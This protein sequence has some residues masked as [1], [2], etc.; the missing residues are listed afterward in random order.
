[1]F[2][3]YSRAVSIGILG[4][5]QKKGQ[6]QECDLVMLTGY[7]LGMVAVRQSNAPDFVR[8]ISKLIF[9]CRFTEG[10][11]SNTYIVLQR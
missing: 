8:G 9:S 7:K 11:S 10:F 1:M 3:L 6:L 2:V 4:E 5:G